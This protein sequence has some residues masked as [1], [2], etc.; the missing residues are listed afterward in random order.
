MGLVKSDW[1]EA[2][3]RGWCVIDKHVC[4]RCVGDTALKEVLKSQARSGR[5][6]YCGRRGE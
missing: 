6:D 3:E 4:T 1:M 2:Q 5:C